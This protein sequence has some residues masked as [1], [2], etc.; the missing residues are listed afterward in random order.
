MNTAKLKLENAAKS[1]D[2][3]E[4][5]HKKFEAHIAK[6]TDTIEGGSFSMVNSYLSALILNYPFEIGHKLVTNKKGDFAM[7]YSFCYGNDC[8]LCLYLNELGYIF[9][10]PEFNNKLGEFTAHDIRSKAVAALS[11]VFLNSPVFAPRV[12][13]GTEAA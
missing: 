11:T 10:D 2:K 7:E 9:T 1:Q 12:A 6:S 3:L 13:I 8:Y 5:M 4:S